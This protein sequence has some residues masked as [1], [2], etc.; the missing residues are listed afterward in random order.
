MLIE[1][2]EV[3]PETSAMIALAD[4]I[5]RRRF[6]DAGTIS[7]QIGIDVAPCVGNC[8]MCDFGADFT[9]FQPQRLSLEEILLRARQLVGSGRVQRLYLMTMHLFDLDWLL[10]VVAAV[11]QDLG[12]GVILVANIGDFDLA[13]ARLLRSAGFD[14]VYHVCRLRE[15]IDSRLDP[16]KAS[17]HG[18]RPR[19]GL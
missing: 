3:S 1:Q 10:D 11:R 17:H 16:A 12:P 19:S 2:P 18:G 13:Q 14:S 5:S 7:G 15:G 9:S 8:G 4:T 6:G